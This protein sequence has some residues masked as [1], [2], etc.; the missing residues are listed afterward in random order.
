MP[1][2]KSKVNRIKDTPKSKFTLI[3]SKKTPFLKKINSTNKFAQR[4]LLMCLRLL[5]TFENVELFPLEIKQVTYFNFLL[6]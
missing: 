5:R 3:S 2:A 1:C 6:R 4:I